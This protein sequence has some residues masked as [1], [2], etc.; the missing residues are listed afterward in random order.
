[1]LIIDA[2]HP[3]YDAS[4]RGKRRRVEQEHHSDLNNETAGILYSRS[5]ACIDTTN[6]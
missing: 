5:E 3:N 2:D 4:G 1:L 6:N